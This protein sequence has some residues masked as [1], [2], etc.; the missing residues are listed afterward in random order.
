LLIIPNKSWYGFQNI[1]KDK[2]K[3]LNI[4]NI[5]YSEKEIERKNI[6]DFNYDW[7]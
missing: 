4:I 6:Q 5:K 1:G 2:V 3:L 7:K